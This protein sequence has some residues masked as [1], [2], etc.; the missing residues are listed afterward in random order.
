MKEE[1]NKKGRIEISDDDK[2]YIT[3][4]NIQVRQRGKVKEMKQDSKGSIE[5]LTGDKRG[6]INLNK[7]VRSFRCKIKMTLWLK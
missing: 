6:I 2:R 5:I 3:N 7:Q 4:L 1:Y